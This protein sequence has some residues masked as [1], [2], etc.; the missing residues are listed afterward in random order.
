MLIQRV[1]N[2]FVILAAGLAGLSMV[3]CGRASGPVRVDPDVA[4]A[5]CV[6]RDGMVMDRVPGGGTSSLERPGNWLGQ[7]GVPTYVLKQDDDVLAALWHVGG[8]RVVVRRE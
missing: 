6:V 3:A 7:P 2:H 4:F 1:R 8:S 5:A